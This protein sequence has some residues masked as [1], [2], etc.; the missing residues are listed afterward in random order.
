[1]YV[2]VYFCEEKLT[3][4]HGGIDE[5]DRAESILSRDG[6]DQRPDAW[7]NDTRGTIAKIIPVVGTPDTLEKI[8]AAAFA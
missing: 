3:G 4:S 1:M 8:L 2:I 5:L 6:Y 7:H